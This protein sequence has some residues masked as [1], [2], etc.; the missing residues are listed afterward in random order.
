MVT[1]ETR[2]VSS[3][4]KIL[5][6]SVAAALIFTMAVGL[7][8]CG[9]GS[10]DKEISIDIPDSDIVGNRV[11]APVKTEY[12]TDN[13]LRTIEGEYE[14]P[15]Y[16][17]ADASDLIQIDGLKNKEVQQTI[18]D[19]IRGTFMEMITDTNP[20]PVRGA[21][22][23][24]RDFLDEEGNLLPSEITVDCYV[25]ASF[26]N[27][28]S[29]KLWK[30]I[31]YGSYEYDNCCWYSDTKVLNFDLNTGNELKLQDLFADNVDACKYINRYTNK[32]LE[33]TD[34]E[35]EEVFAYTDQFQIKLASPFE[36]F[37]D[38]VEFFVSDYDG[39]VNIILDYRTPEFYVGDNGTDTTW[40]S[41]PYCEE[42]GYTEKF[43]NEEWL[44]EDEDVSYSLIVK[45]VDENH[46]VRMQENPDLSDVGEMIYY[47]KSL[48]YYDYQ[49][50]GFVNYAKKLYDNVEDVDGLIKDVEKYRKSYDG[51]IS[52]SHYYNLSSE[53][54]GKYEILSVDEILSAES[55]VGED[56]YP[57]FYDE[58]VQYITMD[59]TKSKIVGIDD[60]FVDGI[61]FEEAVLKQMLAKKAEVEEWTAESG[62]EFVWSDKTEEYLKAMIESI[63]GFRLGNRSL[64]FSF[65]YNA[66]AMAADYIGCD[67]DLLWYYAYLCTG[68]LYYRDFGC[69][70]L[71]IFG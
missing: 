22:L 60:L 44:F 37:S 56:Y 12:F 58:T 57:I 17:N 66:E 16:V 55:I 59:S 64:A 62:R 5:S 47:N 53:S 68:E 33:T 70:S 10:V 11:E 41:I 21:K 18:N 15:S 32:L 6:V 20:P 23:A 4:K 8:A 19:K 54:V 65:K 34:Y 69:K 9:S 28:L 67:A 24:V 36:G 31:T 30:Y 40:I 13:N 50:E 45:P 43:D 38:D 26:E 42:M 71:T 39:S 51:E 49:S 29:V 46:K 63:N 14:A 52:A 61:D 25:E 1:S 27:I 48:E 7:T 35:S 3:F 2:A